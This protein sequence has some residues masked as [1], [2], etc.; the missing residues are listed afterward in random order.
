MKDDLVTE[1]MQAISDQAN[2]SDDVINI[3]LENPEDLAKDPL[4][5]LAVFRYIAHRKV[6]NDLIVRVQATFE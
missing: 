1:V 4:L 5:S 2:A 6:A 3:L